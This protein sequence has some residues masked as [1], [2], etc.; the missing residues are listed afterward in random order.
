MTVLGSRVRPG[1]TREE[2]LRRIDAWRAELRRR[3]LE[4][5]LGG[6]GA[7]AL[8]DAL[9]VA[10]ESLYAGTPVE[11]VRADLARLVVV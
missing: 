6:P 11:L 1:I 7:F 10:L 8:R 2:S 3:A 4:D 9:V 5:R